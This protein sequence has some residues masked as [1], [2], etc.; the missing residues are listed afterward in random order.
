MNLTLVLFE[1]KKVTVPNAD[2]TLLNNML[3]T[4][5]IIRKKA[6]KSKENH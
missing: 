1:L 2:H 4:L 6:D 3:F 5:N